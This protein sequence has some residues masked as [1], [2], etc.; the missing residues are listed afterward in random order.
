MMEKFKWRY[1]DADDLKNVFVP[2]WN[3]WGFPVPPRECLPARGVVVSDREGDL[4][5]GFLYLTDGGIG[6]M[7]WVVSDKQAAVERKRGA[8]EY[9]VEVLA[10]MAKD[11]GM[12]LMFT[13]TDRAAYKN[14]LQKC[15]FALGDTNTYQLIKGL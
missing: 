7:E 10:A 4:Y 2:W 14:G 3:E 5:G 15:G 11:G 13:S 1:A 8:L 12:I 6:W 9:L